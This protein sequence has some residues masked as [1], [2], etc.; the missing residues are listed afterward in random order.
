MRGEERQGRRAEIVG[1]VP[2]WYRPWLHLAIPSVLGAVVAGVALS[3]VRGLSVAEL[4]AVPVT[5]LVSFAFE[6]RV[7]KYVLHKK[8]PLLGLIYRR[9][10]LMHHV[11]YTSDDM[12]MR[13]PRE[14]WLILMPAYA[15]VLVFVMVAPFAVLLALVAGTNVAM[16]MLATSMGFFLSYEWLHMAYHQ[17]EDSFIGRLRAVRVLREQHRRHHDPRLMKRWNFNVTVPV[18]DVLLG[19]SWSPEREA[20]KDERHRAKLAATAHPSAGR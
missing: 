12:A 7:H 16:L 3:R 13:S 4:V 10:E 20:L 5:L 2:D 15:I 14:L 9:H 8:A 19:T 18:F 11:I 1:N 6:W 17:P